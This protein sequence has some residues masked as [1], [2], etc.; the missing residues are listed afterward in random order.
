MTL[1]TAGAYLA[2]KP[3][4]AVLTMLWIALVLFGLG[5]IAAAF[6]RVFYFVALS[7]GLAFFVLAFMLKG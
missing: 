4:G 2:T 7:A 3:T 6:F 5:A 1:M